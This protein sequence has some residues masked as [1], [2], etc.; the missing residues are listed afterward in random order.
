MTEAD[1][2]LSKRN[3]AGSACRNAAIEMEEAAQLLRRKCLHAFSEP[4]EIPVEAVLALHEIDNAARNLHAAADA[5]Y[6]EPDTDTI[7]ARAARKGGK[8]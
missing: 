5:Y 4:A 2:G 8:Q 1:T 7:A 3:A 6:A